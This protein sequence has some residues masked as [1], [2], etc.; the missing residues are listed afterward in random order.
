MRSTALKILRTA[1]IVASVAAAVATTSTP[2]SAAAV[3]AFAGT[4]TIDCFGC[5]DSQG[6]AE[7]TGAGSVAGNVGSAHA[8]YTVHEG[9]GTDCVISGTAEGGVTGALN[10]SFNWNRVGAVALINTTGDVNGSGTAAFV[11]TGPAGLPCGAH[12]LTA[13]VAGEVHA[14]P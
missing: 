13:L 4:A 2:A 9:T 1:I 10:V 7:L 8:D 14:I 12:N 3:V 11:V 6:T 5:G